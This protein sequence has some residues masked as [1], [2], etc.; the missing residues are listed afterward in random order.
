MG[1][2]IFL[3]FFHQKSVDHFGPVMGNTF[4]EPF[5]EGQEMAG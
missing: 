2:N 1:V 5:V 3:E 4:V